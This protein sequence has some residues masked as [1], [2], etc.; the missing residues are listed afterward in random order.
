MNLLHLLS[1]VVLNLTDIEQMKPNT[2]LM[3]V[4]MIIA[5]AYNTSVKSENVELMQAA[6]YALADMRGEL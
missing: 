6:K 3:A 4:A 5:T 1:S 2:K